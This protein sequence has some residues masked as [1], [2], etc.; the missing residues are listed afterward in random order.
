MARGQH[1]FRETGTQKRDCILFCS[2]SVVRVL[3][4]QTDALALRA[5]LGALSQTG[6]DMPIPSASSRAPLEDVS[7]SP[8]ILRPGARVEVERF[9]VRT[10][11]VAGGEQEGR[12]IACMVP[13]GNGSS[14]VPRD[15]MVARR[16]V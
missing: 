9:V 2:V 10:R 1:W 12:L 16:S 5:L 6:L 8:V 4:A 14:R 15:L 7:P 11:H 13:A 3:S